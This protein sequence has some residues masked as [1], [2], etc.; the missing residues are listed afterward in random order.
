MAD[1]DRLIERIEKV[2]AIYHGA[3]SDGERQAAEA[4]LQRI[5]AKM[6]EQRAVHEQD[7]DFSFSISDPWSRDLFIRLLKKHHLKP[8]R[9]PRQRRTTIM[10]TAKPSLIDGVLWPEYQQVQSLLAA[11][12]DQVANE[13]IARVL[14]DEDNS[15]ADEQEAITGG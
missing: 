6:A 8:Y 1:L 11:H 7:V 4:A 10:V 5:E 15:T 13:V 12:L 3:S 14:A 2:M 9:R